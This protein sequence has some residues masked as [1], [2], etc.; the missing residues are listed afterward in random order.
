MRAEGPP[1]RISVDEEY[2]VARKLSRE[3]FAPVISR[4]LGSDKLLI[5]IPAQGAGIYKEVADA[6]NQKGARRIE[7]DALTDADLRENSLVM[8]GT[9][10]AVVHACMNYS[11]SCYYIKNDCLFP[12]IFSQLLQDNMKSVKQAGIRILNDFHG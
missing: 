8:L 12:G 1:D 6:F 9:E 5:V 4:V 10:S 11:V 2:N 7:A 3:E